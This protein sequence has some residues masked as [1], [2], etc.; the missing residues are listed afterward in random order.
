MGGEGLWEGESC[1]E[2]SLPAWAP[3][4]LGQ[5]TGATHGLGFQL[6]WEQS[7]AHLVCG[8]CGWSLGDRAR[9]KFQGGPLAS[10]AA[11]WGRE[12]RAV[13]SISGRVEAKGS[14]LFLGKLGGSQAPVPHLTLVGNQGSWVPYLSMICKVALA[15][16]T[17]SVPCAGCGMRLGNSARCCSVWLPTS[18]IPVQLQGWPELSM[19]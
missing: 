14:W 6:H 18:Q 19:K 12:G 11:F 7:F 15:S 5:T 16:L 13:G 4:C 3:L 17:E 1:G 10:L 8:A 2:N 9:A